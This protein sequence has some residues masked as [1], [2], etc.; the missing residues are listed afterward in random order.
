MNLKVAFKATIRNQAG[1]PHSPSTTILVKAD[2]QT[3]RQTKFFQIFDSPNTRKVN[4]TI[5]MLALAKRPDP[6][7]I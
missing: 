1:V 7:P 2:Q 4:I 3:T 5:Q 6:N